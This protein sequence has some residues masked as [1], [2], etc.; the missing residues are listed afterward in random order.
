MINATRKLKPNGQMGIGMTE[1]GVVVLDGGTRGGER[2]KPWR[3]GKSIPKG[4]K[5]QKPVA[6]TSLEADGTLV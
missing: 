3:L 5:G 2:S 4:R 1:C 6:G